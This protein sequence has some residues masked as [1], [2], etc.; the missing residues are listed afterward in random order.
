VPK[1]GGVTV[2]AEV[3]PAL[4]P[5]QA[6]AERLERVLV[7]LI[8]NAIRQTPPDGSVV[9]RAEA[10]DGELE[11][12][13]ADTGLAIPADERERFF[14]P[15]F[16]AGTSGAGVALAISRAIVEAHGGRIWLAGTGPGAR[17]RFRLPAA[18]RHR[19]SR[20]ADG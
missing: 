3:D 17:V 5:V 4:P 16:R 6:D 19:R 1:Q 7:S 20:H 12:E 15:L 13:V 11:I 2:H 8:Q 18:D 10:V 14:E 9:V